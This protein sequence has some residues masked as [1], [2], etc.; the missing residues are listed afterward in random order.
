MSLEWETKTFSDLVDII[1]G[2]TPKTSV[3][4]YWNGDIR[5]ISIKDFNNCQKYIVDTEK[6]ITESGLKNCSTKILKKNDI[7]ISA[8]G[9]VGEIAMIKYEMAF[10]QSCYGLRVHDFLNKEFIYYLLKYNINKL[11]NMVHGAV[12]DTITKNTFDN[13]LVNLPP[14][15]YQEKISIILSN[16]DDLI[17]VKI[18]EN[19]NFNTLFQKT[20]WGKKNIFITTRCFFEKSV[21]FNI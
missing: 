6:S 5:W 3:E 14:L 13:I 8:R 2:G 15:E 1:G 18:F 16:I 21:N 7:I 11:K 20:L 19:N 10:N 17:E 9:T 4:E 12:F